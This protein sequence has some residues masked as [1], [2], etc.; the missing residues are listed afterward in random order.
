MSTDTDT[1]TPTA[2]Q[3]R[4]LC[5]KWWHA[6]GPRVEVAGAKLPFAI[7]SVNDGGGIGWYDD[8]E[9]AWASIAAMVASG[10]LTR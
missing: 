1:K 3:R 8:G 10:T 7:V 9:Y 6:D 4:S 5:G 2:E